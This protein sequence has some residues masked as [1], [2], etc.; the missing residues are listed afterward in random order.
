MAKSKYPNAKAGS[1]VVLDVETGQVL[2]MASKPGYDPNSFVGGI[3]SKELEEML[4]NPYHPF[5]SRVLRVAEP[6]GSIF[7]LITATA[8][9]ETGKVT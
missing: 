4:K 2:A 1:V 7:K 9:L 3:S 8:A 5:T 6:P